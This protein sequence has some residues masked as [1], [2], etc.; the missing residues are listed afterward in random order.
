M[1]QDFIDSYLTYKPGGGQPHLK[2]LCQHIEEFLGVCYNKACVAIYDHSFKDLGEVIRDLALELEFFYQDVE[3]KQQEAIVILLNKIRM[4]GNR[5]ILLEQ[6]KSFNDREWQGSFEHYWCD[7]QLE[8]VTSFVWF[9]DQDKLKA[10][11]E[12]SGKGGG[13]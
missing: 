1:F 11:W 7:L 8:I 9:P 12:E 5:A 2:G 3:F 13:K 6:G 10:R 4:A